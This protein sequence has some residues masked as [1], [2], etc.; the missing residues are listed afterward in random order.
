MRVGFVINGVDPYDYSGRSVSSAGDVNG[1]G[2]DD[3]IS[4]RARGDD[5][6][7]SELRRKLR[8]LWQGGVAQSVEL[9]EIELDSNEDGFVINGVSREDR[10]GY[11]V[12]SA[13]DVN[14]DGFDDL[15]I[16]ANFDDPNGSFSGASFVVFGKASGGSVELSEIELDTNQFGFVIN[17]VAP[18]DQSGRSVSSAGDVNGDGL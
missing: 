15:I 13:G 6:N 8:G 2:F 3:L 9:S 17:G 1:D 12:S 10:S 16:G 18:G 14:G 4:R 11:S 5:P 7:G